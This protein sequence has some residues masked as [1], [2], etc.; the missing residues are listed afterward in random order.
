MWSNSIQST[1]GQET[2]YNYKSIPI[3]CAPGVH[4][5]VFDL[6]FQKFPQKD[7]RILILG[8][9]SGAFDER[10]FSNGYEN[11]TSIEFRPEIYK[12]KGK[13]IGLDLNNNF[14]EALEGEFDCIVA[15]EIIEHLENHF[16]FVRQ[17]DKLLSENGALYITTPNAESSLARVKFWL[18]G[19]IPCFTKQ[20]IID[21][22]HINPL[23]IN[24]FL[25][26]LHN[27]TK[28]KLIKIY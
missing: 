4:E 16:H 25:Y 20:A 24:I 23:F 15:I 7:I 27:N 2:Q 19:E 9:G 13:I 11:I 28:L 14:T 6:I 26:H 17:I 5:K 18:L 21:T 10:L 8:A 22:G 1:T 3:Y 12:S